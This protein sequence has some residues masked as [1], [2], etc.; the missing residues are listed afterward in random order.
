MVM[1]ANLDSKM[2]ANN[3]KM[4]RIERKQ[5]EHSR[6][7]KNSFMELKTHQSKMRA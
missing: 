2:E 7:L 3:S 6:D 4:D 5:E 1:L